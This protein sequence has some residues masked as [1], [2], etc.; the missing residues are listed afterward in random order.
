[1]TRP[2]TVGQT[3]T[4]LLLVGNPNVGKSVIFG[5]LT[6]RYVTV[7]NYPGT[8]VEIA[9]GSGQAIPGN[10]TVID[11]PGANS[12]TPRSEDEAVTRDMLLAE[13]DA[14]VIQVGDMKN[15]RRVLYMTVQLAELGRRQMLVLNLEDEARD[16]GLDVSTGM[17]EETLRIP[18]VATT[19]VRRLGV[20][21]IP[22]R[23]AEA[24]SAT[25]LVSYPAP[26]EEAVSALS[27]A[28]PATFGD[29]RRGLALML[30][31]GDARLQGQLSQDG[32]TATMHMARRLRE[33]LQQA[34]GDS[35]AIAIAEAR[36][37]AVAA[38][39]RA[40]QHGR[41]RRL[42][43]LRE[44]LGAL[45]VHPL[46]GIPILAL[47][48]LVAYEFVGVLGAGT[49]VDFIEGRV[50]GSWLNPAATAVANLLLPWGWARDLFV[51]QYGLITM[52]V[53]YSIAIVLPVVGTFFIFFGILEDSG[54]LPRLAVMV[55]RLFRTM[56][57]NGKA[58]LPMVLGLGCDTMATLTTRILPSRK[59]RVV[60]TLLLA[61]GV[62][63]S[64]QLGVILAMLGSISLTGTLIWGAVVLLT[65][66]AVG[67]AASKVVPGRASDF[68][69]EIPP[70]RVPS[71]RNILLKTLARTEWYLKE[72]VPLF[73]LGT[74]IL[75]ALAV[76]GLLPLLEHAS[77]PIVVGILG[78]PARAADSF[79]VGFLRRDYGAAGLF[80]L[81]KQGQLDHI[82]AVVSLV[83]I[84]LFVPCI[85]NFFVMIKE[86]GIKTAVA[87][88][89]FIIPFAFAV[90]GFLNWILRLVSINL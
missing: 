86:R 26:V 48:L 4:P 45:S 18:V 36:H 69:I 16:L 49:L 21:R 37:T 25:V 52:G 78:L 24:A 17:L 83:V 42:S 47:V 46:W 41:R 81:Q 13:P 62:P 28:L 27:Q 8:T 89:A 63:C 64:A 35:P 85:A 38:L 84:T 29:A 51:G 11:T 87:Q 72:A 74:L 75:W 56:G 19:A 15:L 88:T 3:A 59:E 76:T 39:L 71:V 82:Q 67:W 22:E 10:P 73:L 58:V 68:I 20:R 57:L 90:G 66:V 5:A 70:L 53:T 34:L 9:R 30:L 14:T 65:L 79:L 40:V 1:M 7:S 54:Y 50:F 44:R 6:R 33:G 23:L 31:A 60:V 80:L 2:A 43:R 12:L 77:E 61:L 55:N 32:D